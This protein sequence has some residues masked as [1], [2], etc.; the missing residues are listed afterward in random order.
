VEICERH[1][2]LTV[3]D[4]V[5]GGFGRVGGWFAVERFGLEP[6]LI[7]FA[8]GVT[9]GYLPLGGVVASPRVAEPFWSTPG[10]T[11]AHGAT[12][13]GHPTCC[14]AALANIDLLERE[15]L[16]ERA[17]ALER[18]FHEALRALESHA[19]VGE[20]RG[21]IGLMAAVALEPG[22]VESDAGVTTRFW[23]EAREAGL[24][25]RWVRDGV[26]VA[27]PLV[28]EDEHVA[29]MVEALSSALDRVAATV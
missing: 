17:F 18:P 19:L 1:G 20:V 25:T 24:L 13:A 15:G 11:F 26:A 2:V 21:G 8:K 10:L 12:Y 4:A 5:I 28:V 9:S 22:L 16:V 6:D 3:A 7:V 29:L 23:R 14:A 27:P